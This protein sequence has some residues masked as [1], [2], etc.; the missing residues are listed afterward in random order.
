MRGLL[1]LTL[2]LL[3]TP[4]F[5]R[6]VITELRLYR[7]GESLRTDVTAQD[8]LDERTAQTINSGLPGVCVYVLRLEDRAGRP[9][10]ERHVERSLS[11]DAWKERYL[12]TSANGSFV[13]PTLAAADSAISRL[14]NYELCPV[15]RL[16]S[17][18]E[19]RLFLQI[20]V[21]P[22]A[23][24]DGVTLTG[25][26]SDRTGDAEGPALD[27]NVLFG[28]AVQDSTIARRI[29]ER[30]SPFFHAADLRDTP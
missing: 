19:Y 7:T 18:D 5:G 20:A 28:H 11:F 14:A 12:L 9:A 25:Y 30:T 16:R 3:A 26:V 23:S 6:G 1:C 24:D 29:I 17:S 27:L 4:A 13:L 21:L 22:L 10:V 8:L 15:S 2:A